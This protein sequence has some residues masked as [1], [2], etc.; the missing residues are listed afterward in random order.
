MDGNATVHPTTD[1]FAE[2]GGSQHILPAGS[3]AIIPIDL[4]NPVSLSPSTFTALEALELLCY[5]QNLGPCM[6]ERRRMATA[7]RMGA[8]GSQYALQDIPHAVRAAINKKTEDEHQIQMAIDRSRQDEA[9]TSLPV[10]VPTFVSSAASSLM[11]LLLNSSPPRLQSSSF[12]NLLTRFATAQLLP[13]IELMSTLGLLESLAAKLCALH[14]R[15]QPLPSSCAPKPHALLLEA[16]HLIAR[17]VDAIRE[18]GRQVYATALAFAPLDSLLYKTYSHL[19][20]RKGMPWSPVVQFRLGAPATWTEAGPSAGLVSV[21]DFALVGGPPVKYAGSRTRSGSGLFLP[22]PDGMFVL[23]ERNEGVCEV[24][25]VATGALVGSV[26][27][28]PGSRFAWVEATGS[29]GTEGDGVSPPGVQPWEMCAWRDEA[30]S[31]RPERIVLLNAPRIWDDWY[32]ICAEAKL[33]DR[34]RML[35]VPAEITARA[36]ETVAIG[37]SNKKRI[38][39]TTYSRDGSHVAFALNTS[40]IVAYRLKPD[41]SM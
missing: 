39:W 24:R 12:Y 7:S 16:A 25:G 19:L 35:I 17:N 10:P 29:E 13:Y 4:I 15:L 40:E 27:F 30:W 2:V 1:V 26:K 36:C 3:G 38:V 20:L 33:E 41:T 32:G 9:G 18:D 11:D 8:A 22:S 31:R 5:P 28:N 37:N 34:F 6:Y 23:V 14:D 21:I